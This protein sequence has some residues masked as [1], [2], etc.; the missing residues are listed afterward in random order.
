MQ[1]C[2]ECTRSDG[3]QPK[4][5]EFERKYLKMIKELAETA[6][7]NNAEMKRR[8]PQTQSTKECDHLIRMNEEMKQALE[9]VK[10][11]SE[12]TTTLSYD[13]RASASS[14]S[15]RHLISSAPSSRSAARPV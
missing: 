2:E 5:G 3:V 1:H 10:N 6:L 12:A 4:T 9:L 8:Q 15:A 7:M 14:R 13:R 11:L